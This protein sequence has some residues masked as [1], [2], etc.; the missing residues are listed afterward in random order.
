MNICFYIAI[1]FYIKPYYVVNPCTK[2]LYGALWR[3]SIGALI[4]RK[5]SVKG[6]HRGSLMGDLKFRV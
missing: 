5:G 4:M 3:L 1:T 2:V 6:S